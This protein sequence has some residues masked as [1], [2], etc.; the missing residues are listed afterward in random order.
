M[1]MVPRM[2]PR[3][4]LIT[5]KKNG[6]IPDTI[7]FTNYYMFIYIYMCM[8]I[9]IIHVYIYIYVC[10]YRP[11][12]KKRMVSRISPFFF[13]V[14]MY[15]RGTIRGTTHRGIWYINME[16]NK[17]LEKISEH[18]AKTDPPLLF[19]S[20]L[21]ELIDVQMIYGDSPVFPREAELITWSISGH[22]PFP[23]TQG[24][25]VLLTSVFKHGVSTSLYTKEGYKAE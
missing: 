9:V 23:E 3:K 10:V 14:I 8:C 4:P 20:W 16:P 21:G 19:K 2:V 6:D 25:F 18:W 17:I 22:F 1:R 12:L 5:V 13:T 11:M 7:L 24:G 15:L